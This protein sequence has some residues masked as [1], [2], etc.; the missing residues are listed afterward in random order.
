V[1]VAE[2]EAGALQ[3]DRGDLLFTTYIEIRAS[4]GR[5]LYRLVETR[6]YRYKQYGPGGSG[7]SESL[8]QSKEEKGLEGTRKYHPR[9]DSRLHRR[10]VSAATH[11][12]RSG[13]ERR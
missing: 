12:L 5:R 2:D 10:I 7:G 1:L 6:S 13:R 8:P 4:M 11:F 3:E 9:L